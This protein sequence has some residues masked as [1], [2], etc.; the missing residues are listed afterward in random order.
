MKKNIWTITC[1]LILAV[2]LSACSNK[3]FPTGTYTTTGEGSVEYRDDGTMT[4]WYGDNVVTNGTYSVENNKIH[5]LHDTYC[6]EHNG[7]DA[8]YK[9]QYK[10]GVLTFELI[11]EDLCDGR[12]NTTSQSYF[13]PK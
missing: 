6:D 4:L 12:R 10:D 5:F 7:G 3:A 9:W 1:I 8:T 11:G 2:T 13:G